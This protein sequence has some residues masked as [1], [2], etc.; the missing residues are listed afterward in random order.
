MTDSVDEPDNVI[1]LRPEQPTASLALHINREGP[2]CKHRTV[3][4]VAKRRSVVCRGCGAPMDPFDVLLR[5]CSEADN[6]L[7][8]ERHKKSEL[9][10]LDSRIKVLKRIESNAKSRLKRLGI[11][12]SS[13]DLEHLARNSQG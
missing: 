4:L 10:A 6:L 1:Q 2:Y 13:W 5:M 7:N 3:D 9:K 8:W 12:P 11:A